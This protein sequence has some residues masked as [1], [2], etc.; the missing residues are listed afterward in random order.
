MKHPNALI[1]ATLAFLLSSCGGSIDTGNTN[2]TRNT[3]NTR[4]G[5]IRTA[6]E[7]NAARND[8]AA[9]Y[10][11]MANIDLANYTNWEPIGDETNPFTGAFDG[12][13]YNIANLQTRGQSH[14]GLFG[15]IR[16]AAIEDLGVLALN[17]SSSSYAGALVGYADDSNIVNSYALVAG[18]V[19]SVGT[20]EFSH[21][22][23][24]V[25]HAA[26][27]EIASSYARV[28]GSVAASFSSSLIPSARLSYNAR[29]GGLVGR[30][31]E[32][33]TAR[34]EV[35]DSYAVVAGSVSADGSAAPDSYASAGGLIGNSD[36]GRITNTYAV[37][38]DYISSTAPISG[39]AFARGLIGSAD[40]DSDLVNSYYSAR[41]DSS[42]F[43]NIR[44]HSR[45][46]RQLECPTGP[47][48]SCEGGGTTYFGWLRTIWNFGDAQTLPTL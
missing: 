9:D 16:E 20:S 21:V 41:R 8:L 30:L 7:L 4:T 14:A 13:N 23:G 47:G 11:L 6:T 36:N 27:S 43:T 15:Y 28:E 31:E 29:A 1:T 19:T 37:V 25:G 33:A 32:T 12:N 35:A 48:Q 17:I 34:S 44:G 22:G 18:Y 26:G 45:T 24:L 39:R 3:G 38:E 42:A 40:D 46:R 10:V 2:G 5:E